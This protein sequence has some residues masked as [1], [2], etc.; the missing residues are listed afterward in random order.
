MNLL[1]SVG[2][3]GEA[4]ALIATVLPRQNRLAYVQPRVFSC[5]ATR[6]TL[7][8]STSFRTSSLQQYT[9]LHL[10]Q[11]HLAG[12]TRPRCHGQDKPRAA[13]VCTDPTKNAARS[14]DGDAARSQSIPSVVN[15]QPNDPTH[16][17]RMHA[18]THA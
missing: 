4:A 18:C 11:A 13:A 17:A 6:Q 9:Y 10:T 3:K 16:R 12:N 2:D 7:F 14:T 15:N 8:L 1:R 5:V